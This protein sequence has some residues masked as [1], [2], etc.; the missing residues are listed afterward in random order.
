MKISIVIFFI[1]FIS[2]T[3][4]KDPQRREIRLLQKGRIKDD[5]SYIYQ[6]PYEKG[7][8]HWL[9]QGYFSNLS[10]RNRAALDFKMKPG[11]RVFAAREGIVIRVIEQNNKGAWKKAYRQYANMIVI[12]HRDDSRAGYW[13]LQQN[14]AMVNI[15]DTVKKGQLI[16]LSGNT[17]YTAFPH[18]HFMVWR[19]GGGRWR[20]VATR[21][22]TEKGIKYLRP[23][24]T[25]RAVMSDHAKRKKLL[26]YDLTA[27]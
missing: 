9:I 24:R 11:T 23:L 15:G 22:L 17:G 27:L 7:T 4:S 13:H 21:F 12:E 18:L 26:F 2:C 14:G 6:L 3:V 1:L 5:T 25:Y 16:G 19:S 8:T 10:H 20:Q